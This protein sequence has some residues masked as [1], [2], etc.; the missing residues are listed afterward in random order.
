M[1]FTV[2]F[3]NMEVESDIV[4]ELKVT[5]YPY[6]RDNIR[7]QTCEARRKLKSENQKKLRFTKSDRAE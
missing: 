1:K 4:Y 2:L 7:A 3:C 6:A 5:T